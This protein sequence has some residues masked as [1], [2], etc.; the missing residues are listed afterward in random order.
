MGSEQDERLLQEIITIINC[1]FYDFPKALEIFL[2]YKQPLI[3]LHSFL[4][5]YKDS[6]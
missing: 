1:Y 5:L 4:Q 2:V 3:Q 6:P